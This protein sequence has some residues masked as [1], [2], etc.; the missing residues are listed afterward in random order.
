MLYAD[1]VLAWTCENFPIL[2]LMLQCTAPPMIANKLLLP[3]AEWC[4][5]KEAMHRSLIRVAQILCYFHVQRMPR[6]IGLSPFAP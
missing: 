5:G 6:L 1:P 3:A 4:G 2:Q